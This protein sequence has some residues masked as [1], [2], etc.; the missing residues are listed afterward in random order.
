MAVRK[1]TANIKIV[2]QPMD[3]YKNFLVLNGSDRQ[4]Y[5]A[6]GDKYAPDRRLDPY[7]VKIECG[8]TDPHGFVSGFVNESLTDVVWKISNTLGG[9]DTIQSTDPNFTIGVGGQKG[10][11][12]IRL[13]VNDLEPLTV[14]FQAK[15][16]EPKSK[17][18]VNF[19]ESFTLLTLSIA[20]A[21]I[22]L[23]KLAPVGYVLYPNENDQGLIC[24]ADLIKG[25]DKLPA[26]YWWYKNDKLISDTGGY[27]GSTSNKLFVPY[28]E[29]TMD[30]DIFKCEVGDATYYIDEQVDIKMK[31]D[32][33]IKNYETL[34]NNGT[35]NLLSLPQYITNLVGLDGTTL[36]NNQKNFD[37]Y[38]I[39]SKGGT[40]VNKIKYEF[41]KGEKGKIYSHQ[42]SITN[43]G[44]AQISVSNNI[45]STVVNINSKTTSIV[46]FENI[47][48]DGV[49]IITTTIKGSAINQAVNVDIK[50]VKIEIGKTCTAWSPTNIDI[51]ETKKY[52]EKKYREGVVIPPNYRPSEKPTKLYFGDFLLKSQYPIYEEDIICSEYIDPSTKM[53]SLTMVI[54]TNMGDL[55]TPEKFFS[56]GWIP[57]S[58][59][60]F[61]YKGFNI[62]IPIDE[63]L[64]IQ[65]KK[66][67]L[68]Y[69]L[70]TDQSLKP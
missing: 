28:N 51:V 9:Y 32:T 61:K 34:F 31:A 29:I 63:L 43:N 22:V 13:N 67:T 17:R 58:D 21:P 45:N 5:D 57:Q 27:K 26:V 62:K 12:Q 1:G 60:T 6:D 68:D 37:T 56:V 4:F 23:E 66:M 18:V 7:V 59:G 47:V 36:T 64:D 25:F 19:L 55:L 49:K 15:Y 24:Q 70:R 35:Y 42:V 44:T 52:K 2:Y 46:K 69:E 14:T 53:V 41:G 16:I 30:G 3:T 11:L 50:N 48:S 65:N 33:D 40:T 54:K 10:E 39:L 8:V 38:N 20:D